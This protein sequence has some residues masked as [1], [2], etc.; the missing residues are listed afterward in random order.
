[1]SGATR[2]DAILA[3]VRRRAA[4]RLGRRSLADLLAEARPDPARR[5]RFVRAL[6]G[7]ELAFIAECKRRSPA[8][9]LLAPAGDL[10]PRARAYARGGAAAISVLTEQDHFHGAPE[11][12]AR[13]RAAGLP[14]LRKDFLLD[15][16]MV[17]ESAALGADAVLLLAAAVPDP[18]LGEMRALAAELGLAVLLEVHGPA[19][20]RRALDAAPD[21]VGVNAR[22][23][24]SFAVDPGVFARLLPEIPPAYVRV[25]ESG[26]RT[27]ADARAARA[28]GADAVLV[29]EALMRAADPAADLCAWR[30]ACREV[31]PRG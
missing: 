3:D 1:M 13:A 4:A 28:S 2:L 9:G 20:L 16:K 31:A 7:G 23:L 30:A 17:A 29:G 11:D 8:A 27:P 5:Q 12:L 22:D 25:A 14:L 21:C 18:L 10:E 26:L 19:E 15:C 6:R 24:A